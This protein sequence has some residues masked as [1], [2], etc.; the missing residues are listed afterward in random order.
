MNRDFYFYG[1]LFN[2]LSIV[3]G[4]VFAIVFLLVGPKILT[5]ES[6]QSWLFIW[7]LASFIGALFLLRYFKR[8]GY[9]F[10]FYTGIGLVIANLTITALLVALIRNPGL[11][12]VFLTATAVSII[13]TIAHSAGLV[14]SKAGEHFW[15]K[16]AGVTMLVVGA[17]YA[18]LLVWNV[19]GGVTAQIVTSKI[20]GWGRLVRAFIPLCFML[21]FTRELRQLPD[22]VAP[23]RQWLDNL[24]AM[25][26]VL[27]LGATLF[28]TVVITKDGVDSRRWDKLNAMRADRLVVMS[29]VRTYKNAEGDTLQYL[30]TRPRDFDRQRKYPLVV[31]LPYGGFQSPPADW[32]SEETIRASYPAFLFVP[33]SAPGTSWGGVPENAKRTPLDDLVF[34]ALSSLDESSIDRDRI[35]ISGVS[36][37]GYGSWT[38]I[39][40]HPE[41]FAAAIPVCGGGD[42]AHAPSIVDVPVWAFHGEDDIAVPVSASREMIEAIKLAGGEPRYTEYPHLAH[43]IWHEVRATP[44]LL[45]WLFQQRRNDARIVNRE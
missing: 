36:L 29:E 44:G 21:Q 45:D 17:T 32:L 2:G 9:G 26:G 30:L 38:L 8:K 1:N 22:D 4:V 31:C 42:P 35:Y 15:L 19:V 43:N 18:G 11:R 16:L 3:S 7:T 20:D 24:L 37:G 10:V 40:K 14:F 6:F 34:G 25:G 12:D 33:Y 27:T 5:F 28:A 41:T 39:S 23:M 13:L